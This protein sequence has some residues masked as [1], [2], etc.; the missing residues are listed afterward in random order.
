LFTEKARDAHLSAV[1]RQYTLSVSSR[2]KGKAP[3]FEHTMIIRIQ[4]VYK[5]VSKEILL[6]VLFSY[7]LQRVPLS[8]KKLILRH[9]KK[10]LEKN[11]YQ[12]FY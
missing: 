5:N 1:G 12:N 7:F 4:R 10:S 6:V 3:K 9:L 2:E 8:K 11:D